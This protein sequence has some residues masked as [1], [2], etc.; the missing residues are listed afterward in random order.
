[1]L[2]NDFQI[3]NFKKGFFTM[4]NIRPYHIHNALYGFSLRFVKILM[5]FFAGILLVSGFLLTA[6]ATDMDSQLVLFQWD[7][8]LF[9]LP[10][11]AIF[12]FI[13]FA[14]S[15]A[16]LQNTAKSACGLL[17]AFVL[18]WCLISGCILI[19]FGKAAPASDG[20]SVYDIAARLAV[21]DT[22]VV[23]P[24]D[25]YLSYYPQQVGLAAFWEVLIRIW[26]LTRIDQHA[27]HFLK[28]V[29]LLLECVIIIFQ[30]KTV[31]ILWKD[32][33]A[34][35]LYL[36]L[37]GASCP[38]FMYTSYLYGEIPSF[39][40]IS[41]S[42][43]FLLRLL[44]DTCPSAKDAAGVSEACR[45]RG[46]HPVFSALGGLF[47]LTLSVMLRKNSLIFMIAAV[48]V[49]LLCGLKRKRPFLLLLAVSCTACSLTVL[50]GI[51]KMY[52]Y[53]SG[54]YLSSGVPA[55]SYFAMGMQESSRADGWYN[56]FNFYT[57]QDTGMDTEATV[58]ISREAIR[59]RLAYFGENPGYA[60]RFY[61]NKYLSQWADGTYACRQSTRTTF[62][63]R[64]PFFVEL[65]EGKYSKYLI[66]YCN[67][68]QNALYLGA[69]WF[70]LVSL[71]GNL[72]GKNPRKVRKKDADTPDFSAGSMS[73]PS[74]E[75]TAKP[76]ADGA[77]ESRLYVYL[78]LIGVF[79]GFL[80][81]MIWEANARYIF[82]YGLAMLPYTAR[83]LSLLGTSLNASL[84]NTLHRPE[85]SQSNKDRK[86]HAT[87][88]PPIG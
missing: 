28:A 26:N 68:Y 77:P 41:I 55:M 30:E 72:P 59:E 63:G 23:H 48:I 2:E 33:K 45:P 47:F 13:P 54:S 79:G 21:G 50:P 60:L 16:A 83:G 40:A 24:T 14:V 20:Y 58:A 12:L 86:P 34:E 64:S 18:A 65:Y 80:F 61:L 75:H 62:G 76:P 42:F 10:P 31:R 71:K 44:E 67:I 78:G 82:L 70:C 11:T 52:E 81:H 51:R 29:Y 7:N 53:R 35:C 37:A 4:A 36:L 19:L 73:T 84:N 74:A 39:A 5:L 85:A 66:G 56:G 88:K 17:R 43:Y 32:Q 49:L 3:P 1:M 27:Y 22:S 6:Y 8:P 57:Y 9:T 15:S 46:A 87:D 69:F 38:L 25:S